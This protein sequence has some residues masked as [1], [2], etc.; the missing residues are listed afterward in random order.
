MPEARSLLS[1]LGLVLTLASATAASQASA[2][3]R[4]L[5]CRVPFDYNSAEVDQEFV[6]Q[7]IKNLRLN[8]RDTLQVVASAT[9]QG[10]PAYNA[11]LSKRRAENLKKAFVAR[12]PGLEVRA[13]A[14]GEVPKNGLLAQATAPE[15]STGTS[16]LTPSVKQASSP[17]FGSWKVGPRMGRD[18]TR[19]EDK[20]Q[21]F[22]PGIE[23][24]YLPPLATPE[25]YV[26]LGGIANAYT[27]V[28]NTKMTS[29]HLAPMIGYKN[30]ETGMIAG[31]RALGGIVY[32]NIS[33][34][35]LGDA[36][37]E[38]R[39]G[40]ETKNW[41]AFLGAGQTRVLQRVGVDLGYKF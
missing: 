18:R 12:V 41:T 4:L 13:I 17:S 27:Y 6:E 22:A 5:S 23:V 11:A 10:T 8:S 29:I 30:P 15:T 35:D 32:S 34:N 1:S 28:D 16:G 39:I 3:G 20:E 2:Q 25:L 7:C 21:Y 26:E 37:V 19:V 36:G 9:P 33:G 38:L 14:I 31:M 24:A 40:K